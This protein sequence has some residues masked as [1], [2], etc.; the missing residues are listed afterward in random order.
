MHPAVAAAVVE[1]EAA[2]LGHRV[3][4]APDGEGGAFV[5]VHGLAFGDAYEP[6]SGWVAFRITHAYPHADIY[7]HFLPDGLERRDGKGLGKPSTGRR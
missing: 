4:H 2:F 1:I 7:P 3:E 5:R 6:G